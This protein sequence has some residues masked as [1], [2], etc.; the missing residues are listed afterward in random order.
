[1]SGEPKEISVPQARGVKAENDNHF[2]KSV[3][4]GTT[5]VQL[6]AIPRT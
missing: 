1:M 2:V 6:T 3:K 4:A 5:P